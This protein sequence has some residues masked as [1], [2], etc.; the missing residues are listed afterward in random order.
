MTELLL[1]D[2]DGRRYIRLPDPPP[3]PAAAPPE[4]EPD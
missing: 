1:R 4:P 3:P 2:T